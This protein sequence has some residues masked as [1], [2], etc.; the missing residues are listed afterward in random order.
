M[1]SPF[2]MQLQNDLTNVF[3]NSEEFAET[4]NINGV[5]GVTCVIDTDLT[6]A[7]RPG[8]GKYEGTFKETITLYIKEIDMQSKPPAYNQFVTVDKNRYKVNRADLFNGLY[9]ISLEAVK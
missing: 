8:L 1:D 6:Q 3:M 5:D 4:H 2:K 7:L 9:E